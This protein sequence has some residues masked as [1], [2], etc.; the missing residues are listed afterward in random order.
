MG[1]VSR[2]VFLAASA[3]AFTAACQ[4]TAAFAAVSCVSGS[5]PSFLP[6]RLTVDCA[7]RRNFALFRQNADYLGLAG[8]V[9]M[10]FVRG[11]IGSY[12]AGNLFLFPWLKPKGVALGVAKVWSAVAP[13][14]AT[15][16]VP[17]GPIRGAAFPQD[18]LFCNAVLQA[19]TTMFIGFGADVP[20]D[21]LEAKLGL[22]TNID[23]LA[24]GKPIG[25]DWASS[26]LNNPWFGGSRA[27]P[28]DETCG[29][30]AWRAL[31]VDGL[32]QASV[33]AC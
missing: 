10:T 29:G 2:R 24:D 1:F 19:P 32:N 28:A 8:A 3:S 14:S 9:S 22:Y 26:N 33:G 23:K 17:A 5:L 6:N 18:E 30:A 12:Q 20:F 21:A 11:K 31:V 13:T 16:M 4:S 27:I 15:A 7:S 25:V